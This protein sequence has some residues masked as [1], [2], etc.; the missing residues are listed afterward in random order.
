MV[1]LEIDGNRV[2]VPVGSKII[3]AAK[4]LDSYIP[5]FCYHKKL[6]IAANC[7]MCLVEVEKMPKMVPACATFVSEGMVVKTKSEKVIQARQAV[8]EFL[9]LNHPIDCPICDQAGECQLQDLAVGYGRVHSRYDEEKRVVFSKKSGSLISMEEMSRCILCTRC[10]RFGK[11][12]A[13]L[14]ELG[15]VGRG[16]HSEI[17]PFFDNSINSELSGN[18]IDI[19]PVGA[20]TSKPFKFS[21]RSWELTQYPS[22]SPHD[23][24]G[25]NLVVQTKKN[26]VMRIL[27]FENE[28]INECWISD[29]DRF[30]YEALNSSE[31]LTE[32][33]IKRDGIWEN[34]DWNTALEYVVNKLNDFCLSRQSDN[35]QNQ[36]SIAFAASPNSTVEELF[37]V[38]KIADSIGA[39]YEFRLHQQDVDATVGAPWLGMPINE[40]AQVDTAL[41]IGANLRN[42]HPLIA[43]R[44]RNVANH[45]AKIIFLNS[46]LDN[47]LIKSS[48]KIVSSPDKW[49]DILMQL[50]N[51]LIN[52][53]FSEYDRNE[54]S[55]LNCVA[56]DL[57]NSNFPTIL[58]GSSFFNHPN[59]SYLYSLVAELSKI[60]QAKIGFLSDSANLVGAHLLDKCRKKRKHF[61][62]NYLFSS[63]KKVYVLLGNEP[64]FDSAN[65]KQ[66][67]N[68]LKQSDFV[69]SLTAFKPYSLVLQDIKKKSEQLFLEEGL[70]KLLRQYG[71][72]SNT[73][74]K[75]LIEKE[76][77]VADYVRDANCYA[78]V[79]LPITTFTENMGSFINMSGTMQ[80]FHQVSLPYGESKPAWNILC[81]LGN[82][83]RKDKFD[84]HSIDK[85]RE[86]AL[87]QISFSR[88][89]NNS[90]LNLR[91]DAVIYQCDTGNKKEVSNFL[92]LQRI[93]DIPIYHSDPLVRRAVSL[94]NTNLAKYAHI[95]RLSKEDYDSLCLSKASKVRVWQEDDFIEAMASVDTSL[96]KG[97]MRLDNCTP[98]SA[99]LSSAPAV[100]RI[101][102]IAEE[103]E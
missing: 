96:P 64:E 6:T 28:A 52:A 88:D 62:P 22:I 49:A 39:H 58:L 8:M 11:E 53:S 87:E 45:G 93:A 80:T 1:E 66:A 5:H 38:Q 42:D 24:L 30:S 91:S 16:E 17:M 26:K 70:S 75:F 15:S 69:V 57:I 36:D 78:D 47:S 44:L 10:I 89:L 29:K 3:D 35:V 21:A 7:R 72:G 90:P 27:P 9:L 40:L 37:L 84:Y 12:I 82:L 100:V 81:T 102:R 103:G 79:L 23:A 92:F 50:T 77:I 59:Y 56:H 25:S 94:Q 98:I 63:P 85:I 51:L 43:V 68:A 34:V 86:S 55:K 71:T 31:R 76:K 2:S 83:L 67:V 19:C 73:Y 65:P 32:P 61:A 60:C 20:I 97:I 95:V 101:E 46:F 18:M 54:P 99:N 33:M 4:L 41:I 14:V 74:V 48:Q 13:G